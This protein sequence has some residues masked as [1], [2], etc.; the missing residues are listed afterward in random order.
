LGSSL[1]HQQAGWGGPRTISAPGASLPLRLGRLAR[2]GEGKWTS[3][4]DERLDRDHMEPLLQDLRCVIDTRVCCGPRQGL[5][6]LAHQ[7]GCSP[8]GWHL[9]AILA[10]PGPQSL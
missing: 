7:Q 10:L 4:P 8:G 9:K 6:G 5:W 3:S 2:S 1:C